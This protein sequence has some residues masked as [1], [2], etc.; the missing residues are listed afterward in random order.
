MRVWR[1]GE[2]FVMELAVWPD[3]A[4]FVRVAH[5]SFES[6]LARFSYLEA[7]Q[8]WSY[9]APSLEFGYRKDEVGLHVP[10]ADLIRLT[11]RA[12]Y[13]RRRN[14]DKVEGRIRWIIRELSP[15][16]TLRTFVESDRMAEV[17]E[18]LGLPLEIDPAFLEWFGPGSR[19][20]QALLEDASRRASAQPPQRPDLC[21]AVEEARSHIPLAAPMGLT[22]LSNHGRSSCDLPFLVGDPS[23]L[24]GHR[25]QFILAL[26][27]MVTLNVGA[28]T[29]RA[30]DWYRE[31]A[32]P[33]L[34]T[35]TN[36]LMDIVGIGATPWEAIQ[37]VPNFYLTGQYEE[38]EA[39]RLEPGQLQVEDAEV[40]Q[41]L[42]QW[43]PCWWPEK[44]FLEYA[45]G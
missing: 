39:R 26:G 35:V 9:D 1:S 13:G 25:F 30:K 45:T 33:D 5:E 11:D 27:Q 31:N 42:G 4:S 28:M 44:E 10:F 29:G 37:M 32:G 24:L 3:G 36:G 19:V 21:D 14:M 17:I 12:P 40:Y 16:E 43:H 23:R 6:G 34:C 15:S 41:L 22:G 2:F 7:D 20:E 8:T 38:W 18:K